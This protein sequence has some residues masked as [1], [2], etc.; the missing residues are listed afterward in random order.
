M[1]VSWLVHIPYMLWICQS[2][3]LLSKLKYIVGNCSCIHW[4]L[5][6]PEEF[7]MFCQCSQA[8]STHFK[9][10]NMLWSRCYVIAREELRNYVGTLVPNKL[11]NHASRKIHYCMSTYFVEHIQRW[12]VCTCLMSIL[13]TSCV[14]TCDYILAP[15]LVQW[16]A[17]AASQCNQHIYFVVEELQKHNETYTC[18]VWTFGKTR[19]VTLG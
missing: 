19:N 12:S 10:V 4:K 1:N 15:A 18:V 9:F 3:T 5:Q 14:R 6:I 8:Y 11:N 13:A 17:C 2:Y 16:L 7:I